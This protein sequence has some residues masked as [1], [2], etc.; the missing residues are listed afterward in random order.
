MPNITLSVPEKQYKFMKEHKEVRWTEI[1]RRSLWDHVYKM[2]LI[3][4]IVYEHD[5]EIKINDSKQQN[6][7]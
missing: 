5:S 1:V 4:N 3:E 2:Q 7:I 6:L